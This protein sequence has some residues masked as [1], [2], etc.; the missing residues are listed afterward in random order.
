[1]LKNY[2]KIAWRNLWRNKAFSAINIIGLALGLACSLLILLWMQDERSMDSFH[3]HK[4]R[5]YAV[6]EREY[7]EGTT[8]ATYA[9][10]GL[11]G[12]EL[13]KVIPEVQYGL[14]Y[15]FDAGIFRTGGKVLREEGMYAGNDLFHMFSFPL[16]QGSADKALSAPGNIAISNK[17]ATA[18]FG[19]PAA[20]MGKTVS[21][22]NR[23]HFLVTAVFADVPNHSSLK[24]DYLLNW[25]TF[26]ATRPHARLWSG[27]GP[28]TAIMLR[29]D[30][31]PARVSARLLK[32]L[33]NYYRS[34]GPGLRKE[35]GM[36]RFDEQY[37]HG[38]FENGQVSGGRIE[39]V[40]LFSIIAVFILLIACINFMNLT[41]A[42]AAK[43][44][45]EIG[46][47]KVAGAMRLSLV[48][49]FI[50]EAM[51][52]VLVATG[53]ALLL[54]QSS[55]PLFN[56]IT[57]KRMELPFSQPG[58]WLQLT[59]LGLLTGCMAGS[60][61]AFFLSSFQPVKVLKGVLQSGKETARFRKGLVVFQ[62]V[63]S[64]LLVISVITV[65]RQVNYI[66]TKQ[67]GYDRENL[68][69]VPLEGHL[70][71][72][73]AFFKQE[74]LK[75]PGIKM[76]T[77]MGGAPTGVHSYQDSVS[78]EGRSPDYR[79]T[80]AIAAVGRDFIETVGAHLVKG[81][82]FSPAF[83]TD[84]LNFLVNEAAAAKLGF[85]D[86]IG[87]ALT[88]ED[89]HRGIIIGI[90][91]GFHT[92]SLH[93]PIEPV[94][95][96]FDESSGGN[97]LIRTSAGKTTQALAALQQLCRQLNPAFPFRY[98]FAD[99]AYQRM[100]K[101]EQVISRLGYWF[102]ALAIVISCMGLLGLALFSAEQ[103]TKE[104]GIRKVL[105]ASVTQLLVLLSREFLLLLL[106]AFA[107]AVPLGWYAMHKWLEGYAYHTGIAWWIFLLAGALS[108]LVA[109]GTVSVQAVRAA[110]VNPVRSLRA[111]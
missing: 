46:V 33:D 69:Y 48:Q 90:V 75:Q 19:S 29:K 32:F 68:L 31:H 5:L 11:L 74:A 49:Q 66:Q 55:L 54:V 36:Q 42:R 63:L 80:F 35:L 58:F 86:P 1:M 96:K 111:E 110:L 22:N 17:M 15:A 102:A 21:Y 47:R 94:I 65:S 25:D 7:A 4:D 78:W 37:L 51:L 67:L 89:G 44:A 57:G 59:L 76:V 84:T 95:F 39:Y 87:Q 24:F 103:R 18:L 34:Q 14:S 100:Y 38:N 73:Y 28:R 2:L 16:L 45:R 64:I 61:P 72:Q 62:F 30:A 23:Q 108:L 40:R 91:Q 20:A 53:I 50:S 107:I 83:S 27:Q 79:P 56:D 70:S 60:Y 98:Q 109:L 9:T 97:A 92:S 81:R 105:G 43:R 106:L 12:E 10:P 93:D 26:L 6:Y 82:D 101:S 85:K 88:L 71:Q 77:Q 41:T 104:V 13:K 99:D 52:L 3:L 8:G